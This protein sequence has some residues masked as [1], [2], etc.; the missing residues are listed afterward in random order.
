MSLFLF[1][2]GQ[3]TF[4]TLIIIVMTVSSVCFGSQRHAVFMSCYKR[5]ATFVS[6][7]F[8]HAL[9]VAWLVQ[10]S[11]SAV[12][13]DL[14]SKLDDI[15]LWRVPKLLRICTH[16]HGA[17][18]SLNISHYSTMYFIVCIVLCFLLPRIP[19]GTDPFILSQ[20]HVKVCTQCWKQSKRMWVQVA[21]FLF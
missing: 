9:I 3:V 15:F 5:T 14:R 11:W 19:V 1:L 6:I 16:N 10:P 17:S 4:K 2:K 20:C 18:D 8:E 21:T 13:Y 7:S 12:I